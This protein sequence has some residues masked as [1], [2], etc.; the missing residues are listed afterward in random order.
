MEMY[1]LKSALCLAIFFVFYKALL[2]N[3]SLHSFKRFYLLLSVVI[4]F[5]IPFITFTTY[6]EIEPTAALQLLEPEAS[7]VASETQFNYL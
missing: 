3:T 4:S 7:A 1:I 6:R 2:E 5:S